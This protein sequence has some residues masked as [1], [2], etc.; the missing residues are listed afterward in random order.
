ML[1]FTLYVSGREEGT[2]IVNS[3]PVTIG[4]APDCALMIDNPMVSRHHAEID[5]VD[6]EYILRD[7]ESGN[8]TYMDDYLVTESPL[9]DGDEFLV[10][11]HLVRFEIVDPVGGASEDEEDGVV[12]EQVERTLSLESSELKRIIER[13]GTHRQCILEITTA[14]DAD[15]V[16]ARRVRLIRPFALIG[17]ASDCDVILEGFRIAPV[18]LMVASEGMHHVVVDLTGKSR[19]RLN[20]RPFRRLQL[21]HGDVVQLSR[22]CIRFVEETVRGQPAS[23][24]LL[25]GT[26]LSNSG[27]RR[28]MRKTKRSS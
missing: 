7:L 9:V 14:A 1:R 28:L 11:K 17:R 15:F 3:L 26:G 4:R 20:G 27:T 25:A 13:T 2:V 10:G 12:H 6:S 18:H 5:L 8:G 23:G 19:A 24:P 16:A 22:H 21:E